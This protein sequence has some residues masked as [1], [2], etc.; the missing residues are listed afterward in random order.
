MYPRRRR[1][2]DGAPEDYDLG[3]IIADR[4]IANSCRDEAVGFVIRRAVA[5]KFSKSQTFMMNAGRPFFVLSA[6]LAMFFAP[7]DAWEAS[8]SQNLTI[9]VTP[10]TQSVSFNPTFLTFPTQGV[11]APSAAQTVTMTNSGS[12]SFPLSGIAI[13]GANPGDFSETNNC[14]SSIVVSASCQISVTFQPMA[15]GP[16]TASVVV[17]ATGGGTY[18]VSLS[19][20]GVTAFFVATNGSDS[21]PGTLSQ[22]FATLGMCQSAMRTSSTTKT[23][24]IRAGTYTGSGIGYNTFTATANGFSVTEAL[25]LTSSDNGETWSY[26]PPD[27]YNTAIFD[28][29][30]G[31]G[32]ANCP[33]DSI[34]SGVQ[35]GIYGEGVNNVTINGLQFRSFCFAGISLRGGTE[36]VA[37]C[38]PSSVGPAANNLIENNIVH[39]IFSATAQCGGSSNWAGGVGAIEIEGNAQS[40]TITHNVVYNETGMGIRAGIS[41]ASGDDISG[42]TVSYNI[43][44]NTSTAYTDSGAIYVGQDTTATNIKVLYNYVNTFGVYGCSGTP[45]PGQCV[46]GYYND[47]GASNI[48]RIGNVALGGSGTCF[49]SHG[50]SRLTDSGNICD[51]G[52]VS[53]A[54]AYSSHGW[55]IANGPNDTGSASDQNNIVI[56]S[57][58]TCAGSSNQCALQNNGYSGTLTIGL[59]DYWNYNASGNG[60]LNAGAIN[61]GDTS[62]NNVDAFGNSTTRC[63]GGNINSWGYYIPPGNAVFSA[64]VSFPPQPSGWATPGFWGPPGY[65][66][67]HFGTAPSYGPTC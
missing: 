44:Y 41:G 54:T 51:L 27:G 20:T 58:S 52:N 11:G 43:T 5:R 17:S 48:T 19:G 28:G 30:A 42:L 36:A 4:H 55:I 9:T 45:S 24:Y 26:Y 15:S 61:N 64:P 57:A 50:G 13:T 37:G 40:N 66:V 3:N 22:P 39:D 47:D 21:Y 65:V 8:V 35:R 59:N 67:P 38:M 2:R 29:N 7:T 34:G 12:V 23:C 53:R 60:W 33:Q 16:R 46:N 18:T 63:P 10:A 56:T 49:F 25:Y 1:P 31:S 6:L 14:P 62:P 32:G